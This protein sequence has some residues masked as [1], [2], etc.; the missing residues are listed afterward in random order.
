MVREKATL[1]VLFADVSD[2]TRL[3]EKMGD[4]AALSQVKGC[5]QIITEVT[6][7]FGGWVIKSIGDG[8]MCAFDNA[9]AAAK[10]AREMQQRT[11]Q[12]PA[13]NDKTKITIRIGFHYGNVLREGR[14]VYGD[15]VNT[16]ARMSGLAA[17]GQI[18][19]T[20]VTAAKLS[21]ELQSEVRQL[22]ALSVKGKE[23][24]VDVDELLWQ[25]TG[26]RTL[27]PGRIGNLARL[28]EP[29]LRLVH[30]RREIVFQVTLM[31]GR[32]ATN[33]IVILDKMASRLHARVEKRKDKF[34]L[35]DQSSNGT[36]ITISGRDEIVLRREEFVLYG[37]GLI[38]F[39]HSLKPGCEVVEFHCKSMDEAQVSRPSVA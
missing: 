4:A 12:R 22:E 7:Q 28:L 15:T 30:N 33:D 8:A 37:S 34:A 2:S 10:A 25:H 5:L 39:G 21:Q 1:A 27:V 32:E 24:A 36:Y 18:I 38:T 31:L 13:S 6:R 19:M 17:A 16:A 9:D 11:A 26:D 20:G 3:Y 35:I 29:Q 14:D 23:G